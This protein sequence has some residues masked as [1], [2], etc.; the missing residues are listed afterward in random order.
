MKFLKK[1][2]ALTLLLLSGFVRV[3]AQGLPGDC[4]DADACPAP[5]DNWLIILV[6][7]GLILTAVYLHNKQKKEATV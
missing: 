2:V 5:L 3:F 4:D 1:G 7:G 6:V